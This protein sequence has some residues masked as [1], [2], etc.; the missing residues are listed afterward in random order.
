MALAS[1]LSISALSVRAC[2]ENNLVE[3]DPDELLDPLNI[4]EAVFGEAQSVAFFECRLFLRG[5]FEEPVDL[6]GRLGGLKNGPGGRPV[7]P[8]IP[9]C[10]CRSRLHVA[11]SRP[12]RRCTLV[13]AWLTAAA[14]A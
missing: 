12:P 5:T 7:R 3:E 8:G 13:A 4:D 14:D 6:L 2:A 11:S 1:H 9:A 10:C